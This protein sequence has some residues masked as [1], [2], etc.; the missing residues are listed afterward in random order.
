M[1]T[2]Y[3]YFFSAKKT[4]GG[5]GDK[6]LLGGKGA[7]L[8]EMTSLGIPVPPGFTISTDVCTYYYAHQNSYP[9]DLQ[10]QIDASIKELET[11]IGKKFGDKTNPLLVS[12]RSGA[13]V[14]MP[15]MM[16]TILNLG[17]NDET[18]AGLISSTGNQR[19]GYD[20]Y[21]RF[22]QMYGN[23]VMGMK[24]HDFEH[25]LEGI[26]KSKGVSEDLALDASDL[27]KLIGEYKGAVK[28]KTGKDFPQSPKEQLMGAID[29]VFASW[30][31]D[32]AITYRKL[33]NIS[34]ALG[35]AVNVQS[36]VFG[37]MGDDCGTG[38]AF[39]R[40]PASGERKFY[41]EFLMNAQGEDVVAGI[42]T[43]LSIEK[44]A[45][46]M[47]DAMKE[48]LSY[49]DKLEHHY[50]DMQDIE[51]TIERSKLYMLQTRSGKRTAFAAIRTAVEMVD[52][53]L[54]DEKIAL[55]R[56][57]AGTLP[58]L[59]AKI[60]AEKEKK[61]ALAKGLVIATGLPAGP[62]AASGH[63]AL[64]AEKAVEMAA[65][66]I[67]SLLVRVETSPEDISGMHSAE[68]ILTARGGMTSH[69]AVVARGMNKPCI[70][71][72]SA[73]E[74]D[75]KTGTVEFNAG[76][77]KAV[78]L[79]EG[80]NLSLDGFTGQVLNTALETIPSELEQ[81]FVTKTMPKAESL[82]AQQYA[83]V[84]E[85]ADKYGRLK[86]RTNADTPHDAAVARSYGAQGIGLCRTEHMF[87]N[88]D[89]I[90]AMR[91]MILSST[92]EEREKALAKLLPF[93]RADFKGI[94]VAME[95][96]P[97][98][99]RL[100]DP[101]L[102]EF[103]PHEEAQID[104][105]AKTFGKTTHYVR[106]KIDDLKEFNPMLG[107]RGCRLGITYPEITAMQTRAIIEAAA[108]LIKEGKK[109]FPEIMV[110][111]VGHVKELANQAQ[112][113]RATAAAVEKE[114]GVKVEY[115]IGTMIEVPRAAVTADEIAA[116]A[117]FFSFGTNDLTQMTSGFSRDDSEHF[118]P[119]YIEKG[120]YPQNP[121][122][123]LDAGGVG[124][125]IEIAI[126]KGRKTNGK[127]KLG[128][129]GE[130]GGDPASISFCDK[131]GLDYVS[132]SPYRVPIAR[133]AAAQARL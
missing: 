53:K 107:H 100:L 113:I 25:I 93:Q 56:I 123:V 40:N 128:V 46:I 103:L 42:R 97:V 29:A 112:V 133:L 30:M 117:Q 13:P 51:F 2:K 91:E 109:V 102:H 59:L 95:G 50:K 45:E 54:I 105:L 33:N 64:T 21:R 72:C 12:V 65:Q 132:C 63:I 83:R 127:I 86:V 8:A 27:Q 80:D 15:G 111:L 98:T 17:L 118:L 57:D 129:C 58:S 47:P 130:H 39:T 43:P 36:M 120:I 121:F 71:G 23:V 11:T 14:S 3:V 99:V 122:Q 10:A 24:H 104:E 19:F 49:A 116:E 9:S 62:G 38:V 4:E 76:T 66:G 75:Y 68:G 90:A 48:L 41:G 74:V 7:N 37:N 87:F 73:L 6:K 92:L 115:A 31:N 60:F 124:K 78:K 110:P 85:W 32:R 22:I 34:E 20:S 119:Y 5:A 1:A 126:E 82:L 35:T 16:D 125:L 28:L 26:K 101:P 94:F 44:L 52:E 61:A 70:V 67:K 114:Q 84:M 88:E 18:V 55:K 89:R 131:V 77:P 79:K 69:A 81:V 96:L 108:E 106:K